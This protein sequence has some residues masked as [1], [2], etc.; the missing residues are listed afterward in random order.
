MTRRLIPALLG[1]A[2]AVTPAAAQ[3]AGGDKVNM[4]IVYGN[5]ACPDSSEGEITVCARKA[6]AERYRI[7]E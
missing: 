4:V 2:A 3:D 1:A 6:E 7:P 5:D